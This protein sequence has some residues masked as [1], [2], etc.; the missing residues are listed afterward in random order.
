M[1]S[2]DVEMRNRR[3]FIQSAGLLGLLFSVKKL[4]PSASL[5]KRPPNIIVIVA[6][7]LGY[8]DLGCYWK[9]KG[10]KG[11]EKIET[12]HIDRLA[13]EGIRFTD[14][15]VTSAVCSPSRASI[16]TGCYP[17]RVGI[18]KVLYPHSRIGLNPS[19]TTIADILK[20]K[21]YHTACIGKWH[22]G[23]LPEFSPLKYGF[24][25]F[26]G[27]PYSNDMHPSVLMRN[28]TVIEK[29]VRQKELTKE[30]TD[31]AIAFIEAQHPEPF[32]IFL[33]H[34]MPHIPLKLD[35]EFKGTS[36]RKKYGD[37][38]VTIDHY[39][40][41]LYKTLE[42]HHLEDNTLIVFTS[43][44]GPWLIMRN[45]GGKAYPLRGGKRTIYEGGFRVPC[46]LHWPDVI[47]KNRVKN[48]FV[49]S[50]DLLPT[51]AGIVDAPLP[52]NRIDG[53]N[54]ISIIDSD[55]D[56]S[57]YDAFYYYTGKR[58][59]AVRSGS[60]KLVFKRKLSW[61]S[62]YRFVKDK[63]VSKNRDAIVP[64]ALYNIENDISEKKNRIKEYPEVIRK[65]KKL[66][67]EA[68]ADLGDKRYGIRGENIRKN[69][70]RKRNKKQR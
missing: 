27:M 5:K 55:N 42:K 29:P 22:L 30:Y 49:T 54:I 70:M 40:G 52:V 60:W 4:F 21:N 20:G 10:K 36:E 18:T 46:I 17:Q 23:V 1:I 13:R 37:A 67:E 64:E 26:Y 19:E 25:Y 28:E 39:M 58:L 8:N 62:P 56:E 7:D 44:N 63:M 9:D 38:I 12:P 2:Y 66:A 61:D 45:A 32:F 53:K 3:S 51:I 59:D 35:K 43:D 41:K 14:F 11:Y 65:L 31:E 69:G 16:L 68:R 15:H 47:P 24:D 6:D 48:A 34:T 50:M 57:P 33:S